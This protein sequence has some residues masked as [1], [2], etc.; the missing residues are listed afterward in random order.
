MPAKTSTSVPLQERSSWRST[1][2]KEMAREVED[3]VEEVPRRIGTEW[4]ACGQKWFSQLWKGAHQ[5][6]V[7]CVDMFLVPGGSTNASSHIYNV[8]TVCLRSKVH[9]KYFYLQS[10]VGLSESTSTWSKKVK[11]GT[12][13]WTK[14]NLYRYTGKSKCDENYFLCADVCII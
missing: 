10:V 12:T 2:I 1:K 5:T 3:L 6:M 14:R 4:R 8:N 11:T 7:V 9:T 13:K